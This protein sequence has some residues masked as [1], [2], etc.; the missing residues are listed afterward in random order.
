MTIELTDR[1]RSFAETDAGHLA[2]MQAHRMALR[3]LIGGTP[4]DY[5][6]A[7]RRGAAQDA[8][9]ALSDAKARSLFP[10]GNTTAALHHLA[11]IAR[12]VRN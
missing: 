3:G 8:R 11:G 4:N 1:E 12:N 6:A 5:A 10:A 7:V 9:M 2:V